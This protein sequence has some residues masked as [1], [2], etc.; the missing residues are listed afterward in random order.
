[1]NLSDSYMELVNR[2]YSRAGSE[3]CQPYPALS[4]EIFLLDQARHK[5]RQKELAQLEAF[6]MTF[7]WQ[8]SRRQR[9]GYLKSLRQGAT[10]VLTDPSKHILWASQS[11]LSMTGYTPTEVLGQRPWMLQGRDTDPVTVD[12]IR[13]HLNRAES[14]KA[15]LVNY[16]KNGDAYLCRLTIDPL[17]NSLGDLT[18]FLAV[19]FAIEG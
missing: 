9:Q 11:F 10:L 6:Q 5:A 3:G 13:E 19:E 16:R 14:V 18:H 7:D 1:M 4:Y 17:H 8:L 2:G 12:R 15:D